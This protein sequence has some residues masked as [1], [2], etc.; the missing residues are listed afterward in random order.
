MPRGAL[1]NI[2]HTA[3]TD[4]RILRREGAGSSLDALAST[5]VRGLPLVPFHATPEN[6]AAHL[7][8]DRDLGIALSLWAYGEQGPTRGRLN[9]LALARLGAATRKRPNDLP[10]LEALATALATD[11]REAEALAA[12]EAVLSLDPRRELDLVGVAPLAAI[13]GRGADGLAYIRKAI[14]INPWSS[15][16]R[17]TLAKILANDRDWQGA[18]NACREALRLDPTD[19]GA[20]RILIHAALQLRDL[21]TARADFRAFE[22]FD[23]P[24]AEQYRRLLGG[25]R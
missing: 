24:D 1:T 17:I 3:A 15:S 4:H 20:R 18:A 9:R 2:A 25:Y 5:E 7:E 19:L 8:L 16:Y 6:S 13:Q 21:S 22:A 12:F 23:P 14:E 10:A 11:G